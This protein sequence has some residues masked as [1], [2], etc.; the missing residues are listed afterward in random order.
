ME[1]AVHAMVQDLPVSDSR[2]SQLQSTTT[3]DLCMQKLHHY[4]ISSWPAKINSVPLPL[5]SF[6]KLK[7]DLHSAE[8]LIL[9]NNRIVI[10]TAMRPYLLKCIHQGHMGI[11]KSK[12]HARAC[13]YWPAMYGDIENVIKQCSVCN[14]YLNTNQ[15]EPLLPHPVPAHPW[16]K[17]GIDFF[18]LDGKDFLLIVD[19]FSKYPEVIQMTS[20]TAQATVAKLKTT[21]VRYSI[22]KTVKADNM[23]F[24]SKDICKCLEL[25]DSHT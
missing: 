7:A 24:H 15:R 25:S 22:P 3:T 12:A 1:F 13:V 6:W 10:P 2:L 5:R 9:L 19:Y 11:E 8:G 4:I 16:E 23:P 14:K 21:F 20:K 17:I 18:S